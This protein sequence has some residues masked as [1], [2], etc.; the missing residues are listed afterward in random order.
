MPQELTLGGADLV[1]LTRD[2]YEELVDVQLY[3]DAKAALARGED[4]LLPP[5]IAD[6]L[7]AGENPVRVFRDLRGMTRKALAA[8]AGMTEKVLADIET[9][10]RKSLSVDEARALAAALKVDLDDIA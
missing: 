5:D 6:R 4:E 8:Q 2:E 1:V 9:G 3:L 7:G 10:A